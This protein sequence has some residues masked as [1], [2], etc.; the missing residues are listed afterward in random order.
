MLILECVRFNP[1]D[2]NIF[3]D[4]HFQT[5]SA[6][7]QK[8]RRS[9]PPGL[10]GERLLHGGDFHQTLRC[11]KDTVTDN[12]QNKYHFHKNECLKAKSDPLIYE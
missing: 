4:T 2:A 8:K 12:K 1:D 7:D 9:I 5:H 10:G 3:R 6:A 11:N